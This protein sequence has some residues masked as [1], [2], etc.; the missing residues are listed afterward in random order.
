MSHFLHLCLSG[1]KKGEPVLQQ[2]AP[3]GSEDGHFDQG[4]LVKGCFNLGRRRRKQAYF[5]VTVSSSRILL[6]KA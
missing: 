6:V 3:G 1:E 2:E 5:F 4:L